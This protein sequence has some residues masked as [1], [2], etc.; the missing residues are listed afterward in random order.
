MSRVMP[1]TGALVA[2]LAA[3]SG[4]QAQVTSNQDSAVSPWPTARSDPWYGSAA[5]SAFIRQAIRGNYT[6]VALGRLADSRAENDDVEEFAERMVSDHNSMNEK[7]SDLARKNDM[8]VGI[9]FGPTGQQ[10]IERLENLSGA[11]FDRAY[12]TEMIR[13][14]EQDLAAFQRMS[15]SASSAEVRQLAGS[16]ASTIRQHLELARQVG[17][18]VGIA[19]TA[20]RVGGVPTPAPTTTPAP[21]PVP[22]TDTTDDRQRRTTVGRTPAAADTDD[23]D[24][25][26]DRDGPRALRGEDRA[27]VQNVLSDHLM[28]V[29]LARRAKR[30][31]NDSETRRL[32]ESIE[33]D[34]GNWAQRWERF[35]D[36][37]DAEVNS[38]LERHNREKLERLDKAADRK[39]FDRA[40]AA[41][42]ADHLE[43]MVD[44]FRDEADEDRPG[45]VRRLI[46]DELPVLR[47]HLA[48]AR[49]LERQENDKK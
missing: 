11:A 30:E 44:D 38:R 41:I 26:D 20:G 43:S 10:T 21:V 4:V 3:A 17:T 1:I 46:Q 15:T 7:W 35:A 14:H 18:R 42:V 22:S 9:D 12:M 8:K 39:Q 33:K 49:R 29:R 28:H 31:T 25:R 32:A 24:D 48:R 45:A 19:S 27:F 40:Y 36:R 16:G 6:E 5:D 47:E 37:R 23:R 13:H 2:A 34:F